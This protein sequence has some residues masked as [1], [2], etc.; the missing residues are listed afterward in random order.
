MSHRGDGKLVRYLRHTNP[1]LNIIER[2]IKG[3]WNISEDKRAEVIDQ[4][5]EMVQSP[6]RSLAVKAA[7]IL[8][9]ALADDRRHELGVLHLL[10]RDQ[11]ESVVPY[12]RLM[13]GKLVEQVQRLE[14][15]EIDDV[16]RFMEELS[17]GL[18]EPE[19]ADDDLPAEE[20]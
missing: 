3:G 16:H 9:D 7:R 10:Q 19:K 12:G 11:E 1:E 18:P 5:M 13:D 17:V 4:L 6:N 8:K 20:D 2:A 15:M 14:S